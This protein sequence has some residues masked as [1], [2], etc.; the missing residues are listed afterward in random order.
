MCIRH[1]P[2]HLAVAALYLALNTYGVELPVGEKEWWQVRIGNLPLWDSSL[3][4][5]HENAWCVC[6]CGCVYVQALCEDI[7]KANIDAV[8]KDLLQLYDLEAKCV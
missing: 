6:L 4:K 8:I 3:F 5:C 1:S 2:Q 7:T